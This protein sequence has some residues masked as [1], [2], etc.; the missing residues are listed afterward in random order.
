MKKYASNIVKTNKPI[1]WQTPLGLEIEQVDFKSQ[2]VNVSID[3]GRKV[4]FKIYTDELDRSAHQ[5]GLSPNY[6]H[7]LDASHLMMTLNALSQR[8]ID[9][10]VTVHDSFATH[11]NDVTLLSKTLREA[12]VALHKKEIL[13]ELCDFWKEVFRVDQKKIPYVDKDSFNLDE[14]LNSEYFFA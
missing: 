3:G 11:A 14:I 12:F 10:I 1:L 9:D 2:K 5:K 4:V 8:A 13:P 7:S 6:I